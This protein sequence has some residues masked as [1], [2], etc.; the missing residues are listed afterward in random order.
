MGRNEFRLALA[1]HHVY[2][3]ELGGTAQLRLMTAVEQVT[4]PQE[5]LLTVR[6]GTPEAGWLQVEYPMGAAVGGYVLFA[7]QGAEPPLASLGGASAKICP[8]GDLSG[9]GVVCPGALL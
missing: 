1:V 7:Q 5:C 6:S 9:W 8:N 2:S 3:P 4:S